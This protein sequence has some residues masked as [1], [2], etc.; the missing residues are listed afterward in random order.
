M[1]TTDLIKRPDRLREMRP[2]W[3]AFFLGLQAL[4]APL[5]AW[6]ATPAIDFGLGGTSMGHF[7]GHA[8]IGANYDQ[9]FFAV[10]LRGS[11]EF[12][13]FGAREPAETM[14]E[15]GF[16]TGPFWNRTFA[17]ASVGTGISALHFEERTSFGWKNPDCRTAFFCADS[18]FRT[19]TTWTVGV[20]VELMFTLKL[21]FIGTGLRVFANANVHDSFVGIS[22]ILFL[23][24]GRTRP[25][26]RSGDGS[27]AED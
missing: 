19:R 13:L 4:S 21:W 14:N 23:G 24:G 1:N 7:G 15:F 5:S 20:P 22:S 2:V 11:S 8:A 27:F 17:Y 25:R 26:H 16:L 3:I 6:E 9:M 18:I 12:I 10:K